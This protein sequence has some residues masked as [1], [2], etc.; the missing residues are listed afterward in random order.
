MAKETVDVSAVFDKTNLSEFSLEELGNGY[1]VCVSREHRFG[2]DAFLLADFAA[3]RRKDKVCDL[4]S[5]NGIVA[6]LM[7][8]NFHP[9]AVYAVELQKK[10]YIQ[11]E[12]SKEASLADGA[13]AGGIIPVLADV[14]DWRCGEP[15]DL[16]TC[17]P[18]YKIDN[19]GFKNADSAVSIA[20]H[21]IMCTIY[22]VCA[23]AKRSLRYGGRLCV[24]NRPERLADVICAMRENKI[25]PKRLRPV[26]KDRDSDPWLIL[27]EGRLGGSKYL[28]MEKPLYIKG[29]NGEPYS[30][31]M[32]RIYGII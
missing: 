22:D 11:L 18:P 15:L 24:C 23:A 19:T 20:R 30:P 12:R 5:G 6:L 31:E 2:T 7:A 26:Q 4:C 25:E 8:R 16:I 14:K 17:N 1:K 13:D 3:P 28:K 32:K 27:V 21:E 29:K 10:A 9:A